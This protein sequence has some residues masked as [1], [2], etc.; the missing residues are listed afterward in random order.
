MNL[1]LFTLSRFVLGRDTSILRTTFLLR[2]TRNQ[3]VALSIAL[4]GPTCEIRLKRIYFPPEPT[5]SAFGTLQD[6]HGLTGFDIANE[7]I[8]LP[9]IT[10]EIV[11][12]GGLRVDVGK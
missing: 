1:N 4:G 12:Q 7:F 6:F 5:I 10:A 3:P 8:A 9:R 2:L 11:W